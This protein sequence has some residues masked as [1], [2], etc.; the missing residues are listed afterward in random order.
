MTALFKYSEKK[1]GKVHFY[2]TNSYTDNSQCKNIGLYREDPVFGK[3]R[4]PYCENCRELTLKENGELPYKFCK[5]KNCGFLLETTSISDFC[6]THLNGEVLDVYHYMGGSIKS[7]IRLKNKYR[8]HKC[9]AKSKDS[10]NCHEPIEIDSF[11]VPSP[12]CVDHNIKL[13]VLNELYAY[14]HTPT[15]FRWIPHDEIYC[16]KCGGKDFMNGTYI[17]S[18]G[19]RFKI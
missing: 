16:G 3:I 17:E 4:E 8:N 11:G 13:Y 12:F 1:D 2:C 14:C 6:S 9:L 15:C 18:R 7:L 5:H 19:Q 10:A